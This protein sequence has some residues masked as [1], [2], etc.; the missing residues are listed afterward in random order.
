MAVG[1]RARRVLFIAGVL[2]LALALR[3]GEVQRTSYRPI[4]DAGSY[5]TLASQIAHAGDYTARIGAGGT[6]GPT[7]YFPPGFPY[8]LAAVDLIDGHPTRRDGAIH[9]A[10][11]SQA[12]IGT[13]VVGLVG[14]VGT[15]AFGELTGLIA[16][17]LA[18]IYPVL[19]E[20]SSILVAEN[21]FTLLVL[22]AIWAMLGAERSAHPYRWIAAA[23]ALTGLATLTHENGVLLVLPLAY[24]GWRLRR[25]IGAELRRPWLAPA[26]LI[27][28]GVVVLAPWLIRNATQLHQFVPVSD[29][30]GISLVG[31][32]NRASAANPVVPYKWRI[33]YGIP[34][35]RRLIRE[36]KHLSEPALSARLESQAFN[37]I[38][39]HPLAPLAVVYHN[40]LRLLELEGSY[41]WK[42]SAKAMSLPESTARIGVISFW[43]LALL[44]LAGAFTRTA[45]R[46]PWWLWLVPVLL[47]LSV[48]AVNVETPRFREP[49]DPFLILLAACALTSLVR[50]LGARLARSPV[51]GERGTPVAGRP[52]QLVQMVER[53]A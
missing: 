5:L 35:E 4:N 46:A 14:L 30:T 23:G 47:W 29:E 15:A 36:S 2:V 24:A 11:L 51:R 28:A 26:V 17:L 40:S 50:A 42:A 44:A 10:R 33:Y 37:Y 45:R 13:A 8:L 53:L 34:G 3:I 19:I 52:G 48:A 38:G 6:R 12:V 39:A 41:A 31:T 1:R 25:T 43:V 27:V 9:P 22:A 18:A 49:V 32:Y 7:A 21:L 16:L 20:L